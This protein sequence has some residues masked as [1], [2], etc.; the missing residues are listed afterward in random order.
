MRPPAR[1]QT[2]DASFVRDTHSKAL[3]NTN[4]AALERH[5]QQRAKALQYDNA[6]RKVDSL[7]AQLEALTAQ[8]EALTRDILKG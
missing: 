4:V 6:A 1:V 8:V 3:L 7:E 5:R 2:E